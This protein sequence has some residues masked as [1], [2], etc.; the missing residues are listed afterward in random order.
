MREEGGRDGKEGGL[1]EERNEGGGRERREG[2]K[3]V[4]PLWR[5]IL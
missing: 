2:E 4:L 1:R 3:A 5:S